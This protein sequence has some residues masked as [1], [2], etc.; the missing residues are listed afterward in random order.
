[1]LRD[2]NAKERLAVTADL[3]SIV[4]VSIAS[5]IA[6]LLAIEGKVDTTAVFGVVLVGLL[7]LAGAAL[8]LASFLFLSSFLSAFLQGYRTIRFLTLFALWCFFL[9]GALLAVWNAYEVLSSTSFTV[10]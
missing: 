3:V 1:M 5:I 9:A 10:D 2:G 4:G 6:A 8:V 7:S